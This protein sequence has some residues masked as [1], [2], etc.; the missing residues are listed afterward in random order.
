MAITWGGT[1][2]RDYFITQGYTS[3]VGTFYATY[4]ARI[5]G[6]FTD[7][8]RD[9]SPGSQAVLIYKASI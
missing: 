5:T 8:S 1:E 4:I 7:V 3:A 2:I 6:V 9:S